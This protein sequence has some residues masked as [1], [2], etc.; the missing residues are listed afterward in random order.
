LWRGGGIRVKVLETLA[1][2]KALVATPRAVEGIDVLDGEQLLLADD[3]ESFSRAIVSVIA[4]AALR[5]RLAENAR[6][7]AVASLGSDSVVRRYERVWAAGA[8]AAIRRCATSRAASSGARPAGSRDAL[9]SLNALRTTVVRP[10]RP[11]ARYRSPEIHARSIASGVDACARAPTCSPQRRHAVTETAAPAVP[12]R[13][14]RLFRRARR[15]R[16]AL[17]APATACDARAA[18]GRHRPAGRTG[19]P[20]RVRALVLGQGF[21]PVNMPGRDLHAVDLD[22]ESR[23]FLWLHVQTEVHVGGSSLPARALL[24]SAG[25]GPVP[26]PSG[27]VA[28]VAAPVARHPR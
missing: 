19:R 5:E 22:D 11:L 2:G 3:V 1:A 4:D 9:S 13:L 12:G 10:A 15:G 14:V 17:V 16:R 21:V 25:A 6:R 18:G 7:W 20:G 24:D 26:Q 8:R 28:A 27:R 23:T